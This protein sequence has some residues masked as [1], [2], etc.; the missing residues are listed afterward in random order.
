[1]SGTLSGKRVLVTGA[2]SGIGLETARLFAEEGATVFGL[3]RRWDAELRGVERIEGDVT[4]GDD[5]SAAV[6]RA[7]G[8]QGLDV[9]VANAGVFVIDDLLTADPEAWARVLDVNLLGV[10]RCFQAAATNMIRHERKGRL[11]ATTSIS[12][13]RSLPYGGAYSASKAGVI[14]LVKS[15]ALAFAEHEITVNA[16]APGNVY[17]EMQS[18]SLQIA[19]QRHQSTV[20][21]M[22]A[23]KVAGTPLRRLGRPEEIATAFLFLAS[24]SAAYITGET[25]CVDGGR[26][27]C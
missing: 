1:M 24:D 11:L 2:S 21:E 16:V 3:D 25:I 26:L 10:L 7:A 15:A 20:E 19:A 8:E 17:T 14:A 12:G 9:L 4:R 27:L 6:E 22:H 18:E 13:L 5:V 23:A